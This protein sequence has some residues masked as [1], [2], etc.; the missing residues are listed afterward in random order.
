[1]FYASIIYLKYSILPNIYIGISIFEQLVILPK[2]SPLLFALPEHTR[3]SLVDFPLHL[4]LELLGVDT[5]LK[6]ITCIMLENK[7]PSILSPPYYHYLII[8]SYYLISIDSY[9]SLRY[10]NSNSLYIYEFSEISIYIAKYYDSTCCGTLHNTDKTLILPIFVGQVILQSRDYNAVSMS[11]MAF[12]TMLY[13]LEYMFPVIP[14]LPTCMN[15]CE[16]VIILN[17][18]LPYYYSLLLPHLNSL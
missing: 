7:V 2:V 9:F 16:Q 17:P 6:V 1:M 8:T 10:I 14:L 4:P 11:V 3:F 5:C 18:T 12:V 13:P 15:S